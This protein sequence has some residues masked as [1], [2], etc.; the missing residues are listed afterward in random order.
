MPRKKLVTDEARKRKKIDPEKL[1]LAIEDYQAKR[2]TLHECE[3]IHGVSKAS[4]HDHI[5]GRWLTTTVGR[6]PIFTTLEEDRI[7]VFMDEMKHYGHPLTRNDVLN[8]ATR[9]LRSDPRL[10]QFSSKREGPGKKNTSQKKFS[11]LKKV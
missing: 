2:L 7:V 9:M 4:I 3:R 8:T 5:T 1:R 11:P 10:Y 6:P